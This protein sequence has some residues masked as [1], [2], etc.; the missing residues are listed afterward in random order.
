M[1]TYVVTVSSMYWSR[2]AAILG[3]NPDLL[4]QLGLDMP[5]V[6]ITYNTTGTLQLTRGTLIPHWQLILVLA[7]QPLLAL[8]A[9]VGTCMLYKTPLRRGFGMIAVLAGVQKDSLALLQG[10]SFSGELNAD[11]T[12]HIDA[13]DPHTSH[14]ELSYTLRKA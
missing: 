3:Q 6:G 13:G 8:C 9:Y 7:V 12:L 2:L 4:Q 5:T 14:P 11:V 10:A 1:P